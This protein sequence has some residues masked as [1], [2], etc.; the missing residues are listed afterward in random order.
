MV[1]YSFERTMISRRA[2]F[3]GS[4]YAVAGGTL[5]TLPFGQALLAQDPVSKW[6]EVAALV[7]RYVGT[8]KLANIVASLGEGQQDPMTIARGGLKFGRAAPADVNSLYRLYSSTKPITGMAVMMLIDEG[9]LG[10]DQSLAEVLPAFSDMRVLR[11]PAGALD[12]TVPTDRP[13]TMRHLLTH[14]AGL[15]YDIR[16]KGP[17]LKAYLDNGIISGQASR[18]PIPGFPNATPAPGLEAMVDRLAKLPLVAQPGTK[19]LYSTS[20]DVLGRVVE[21]ASGQRF[22]DFLQERIFE[23]CGMD[24]T[25]FRVPE[26]EVG[27]LT[28]NYGILGGI[29]LPLDPGAAS[30]FL[31]EPPIL[32]GGSGL[33][34]ST[35]DYDRFL[36][37]LLGYGEIDGR[38]VMGELAVRVGAS[39]LL[40]EGVQ[41][42]S[43]S[44]VNGYGFGAG[45][46]VKDGHY[47]WGGAAGTLGA[48]EFEHNLRA[49]LHTQYMPSDTYPI[50]DEFEAAILDDIASQGGA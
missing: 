48:V 25:F 12:D 35:R 16:A 44:W 38:R 27:R 31:D 50:S 29:P 15:T 18:F 1:A 23:P 6:P 46:R 26:S 4:A 10:L 32:W 24:S 45:G 7:D 42:P 5:A 3:R 37:M 34:S 39:N 33:V 19:W 21:V 41:I 8:R 47:G 2:L 11:N 49:V 43:D 17:I 30:I 36:Q 20:I 28:D 14:T 9:K 13:I 40:P 22:D